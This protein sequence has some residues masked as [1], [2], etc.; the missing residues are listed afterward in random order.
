MGLL[1]EKAKLHANYMERLRVNFLSA[2]ESVKDVLEDRR[3][4]LEEEAEKLTDE[5][6]VGE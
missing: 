3:K 6:G 5:G 1:D 2:E 4:Y